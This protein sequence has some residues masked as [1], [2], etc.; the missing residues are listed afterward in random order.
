MYFADFKK[1][2][3][4]LLKVFRALPQI[5]PHLLLEILKTHLMNITN[6]FMWLFFT[7]STQYQR[8]SMHIVILFLLGPAVNRIRL[9]SFRVGKLL[10]LIS[11]LVP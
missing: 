4:Q 8:V 9:N 3:H 6:K 7:F 10:L 2:H 1:R 11:E 5:L